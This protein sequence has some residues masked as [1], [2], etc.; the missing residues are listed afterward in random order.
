MSAI[1]TDTLEV[2]AIRMDGGTQMRESLDQATVERY[3]EHYTDGVEFPSVVVFY[4]GQVYWLADGFHRV[5]AAITA[6]MEAINADIRSGDRMAA[7]RY[8]LSA[9][10]AN[11]RPRSNGDMRRAYMV[12]V[13]NKLCKATDAKAIKE[14]LQC[15]VQWARRL[16][17]EVRDK[18]K[19]ERDAK[20][21]RLA[22]E[23]MTQREIGAEVG[24]DHKTV[25]N[26]LGEKGNSFVIPQDIDDLSYEESGTGKNDLL[27]DS[28]N[29]PE[30]SES[31]PHVARSSGENEWYTPAK[32]II[33]A[34][35]V[36]G[37][38]DL[39]PAS[40]D[41]A[42]KTVNA[43]AYYTIETDGLAKPWFGN[44][45]LNPPYSKDLVGKFAA[46]LLTSL[47]DSSVQ[48]AVV[49]VNNATET[50]WFQSLAVKCDAI[51][52]P[53]GRIQFIDKTGMVA[54]SP[55]QG[56]ALLYFGERATRF[57][58]AFAEI[59]FTAFSNKQG[60]AQ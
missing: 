7:I 57:C 22:N 43:G 19:A 16:T 40:S 33:V 45:W 38:I 34:A 8:A 13:E 47:E 49:L 25:G 29:E 1:S 5:H 26:V 10:A 12:A 4:D 41:E 3:A 44:V 27:Q 48:Q 15:S 9:N 14:L 18:A 58:K 56:Q 60:A 53:C 23:G 6:K 46:K 55:L 51:C 2:S 30:A 35:G 54:N 37:C 31:V 11:G 52:F 36:M 39:D 50:Q 24:V 21:Q 42:Q 20:I 32:F 17:Q 28:W 59:G